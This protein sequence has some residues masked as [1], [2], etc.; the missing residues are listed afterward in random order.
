[1]TNLHVICQHKMNWIKLENGLFETGEWTVAGNTADEL[2]HTRGRVFLHEKQKE[3]AWHG[4][5]V[6]DWR[7]SPKDS[8][9]K[10]FTYRVDGPFR[11]IC[12][13]NWSREVAIVRE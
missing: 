9:R 11:S 1:M 3:K 13:G 12:P 10:I 8:K 6:L 4:G 7:P 5:V 2:K